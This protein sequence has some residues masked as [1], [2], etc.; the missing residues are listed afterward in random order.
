MLI[1]YDGRGYCIFIRTSLEFW[2]HKFGDCTQTP[3]IVIVVL[4][5]YL[6]TAYY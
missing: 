4:R 6:V 2:I 1:F 5:C 3:R